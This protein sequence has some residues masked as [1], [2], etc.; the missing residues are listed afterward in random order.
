MVRNAGWCTRPDG[1]P[2]FCRL[3]QDIIAQHNRKCLHKYGRVLNGEKPADLP[4][5]QGTQVELIINLKTA[6]ALGIDVP[7]ALLGRADEV[8][9][10]GWHL[11]CW[12]KCEVPTASRNV[13]CW[14]A[15]RKTSARSEYFAF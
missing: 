14:G 6:K 8:I 13:W 1:C 4:V 3:R 9:E 15:K 11:R 2:S 12:H 10:W 7:P 5:M